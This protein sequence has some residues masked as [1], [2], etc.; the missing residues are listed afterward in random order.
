LD[1]N[2]INAAIAA[3]AAALGVAA[4]SAWGAWKSKQQTDAT[5]KTA[6]IDDDAKMRAELWTAVKA[7]QTQVAALSADLDAARRE[8]IQ[9]LGEHAV[10]KAEH[11]ALKKDYDT[12]LIRYAALESRFNNTG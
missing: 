7:T 9:L 4:K 10:L 11:A 12:L 2:E 1:A 5:V 6:E 3:V 8:F